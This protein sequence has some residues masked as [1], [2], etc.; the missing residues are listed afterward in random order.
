MRVYLPVSPCRLQSMFPLMD[1]PLSVETII[2]RSPRFAES[3][4]VLAPRALAKILPAIL[5]CQYPD[6]RV[7]LHD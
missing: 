6:E 3:D 4:G 1:N 5:A 7:T 2:R